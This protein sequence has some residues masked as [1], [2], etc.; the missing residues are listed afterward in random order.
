ML[1]RE[2][3]LDLKAGNA[4]MKLVKELGGLFLRI[5]VVFAYGQLKENFRLFPGGIA[6]LPALNVILKF[7]D[8]FLDF[9]GSCLVIPE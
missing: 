1:A 8:F 7:A 5:V 4:G 2:H 9:F 3:V 6:G